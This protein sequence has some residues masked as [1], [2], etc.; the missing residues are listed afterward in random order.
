MR[1]TTAG[2]YAVRSMLDL[3]QNQA[4]GPVLRLQIAERQQI[5]AENIAQLFRPLT[6]DGLVRSVLGP[7]GG[8]LLGRE[9]GGI[10]I[11]DIIRSV[12][13]PIAAVYCAVEGGKD[14]CCRQDTCVTRL[15]WVGLSKAIAQYLDS[16]T[17][18]DLC[19]RSELQPS[20]RH[21][22]TAENLIDRLGE[23]SADLND[24][25]PITEPKEEM[26]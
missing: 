15:L 12:E 5:S 6:R 22:I 14:P 3:A 20:D 25:Q 1:I 18:Q 11:G 17:L 16:I 8:Y 4:E 2:R 10:R 9:A 26:L 19:Q 7:G 13:G 21:P 24:C 23:F